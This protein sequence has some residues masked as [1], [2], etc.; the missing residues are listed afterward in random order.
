VLDLRRVAVLREFEAQGTVTATAQALAFT[1][2]AVSQ[3]LSQL[4]R[5][6]GVELFRRVGRRLELTDAGRALARGAGELLAHSERLEAELAAHAGELRGV[7][8]VAAFQTASRALVLPAAERLAEA[9]PGLRIQLVELDAEDSLP[10]LARGGLDLAI[11]EEYEHA[12]RPRLQG[13][14]REYLEPDE[15]VIALPAAERGTG[16]IELASLSEQPW[17]AGREGTAFA[18]MFARLCRSVGGFEPDVRHRANDM[19][20]LLD[21]VAAGFAAIVPALGQP[22]RDTRVSVHRIAGGA[23]RA[24][25]VAVRESDRSRPSTAAALAAIALPGANVHFTTP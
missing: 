18:D 15:L 9:E 3:Q 12:P 8:R 7:V 10:L 23:A 2:S 22:D 1:P 16:P 24:V 5:E 17:A 25:F 20:L 14:E 21:L 6:V 19:Q 11:A 13:L 4:Q